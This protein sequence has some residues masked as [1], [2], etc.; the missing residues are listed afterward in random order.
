M[1]SPSFTV[2][3]DEFICLKI[4]TVITQKPIV[5]RYLLGSIETPSAAEEIGKSSPYEKFVKKISIQKTNIHDNRFR[6]L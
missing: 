5:F 4:S 6:L 1:T 2:I 3:N